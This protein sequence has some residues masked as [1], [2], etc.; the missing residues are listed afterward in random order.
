MT[1]DLMEVAEDSA[2]GSFYLVSGNFIATAVHAITTILVGRLLGPE[3]FGRY[4]LS[5]VIPEL[6]FIFAD[7]GITAGVVK[8]AAS[9]RAEGKVGHATKIIKHA[10]LLRVL[11]GFV[12]SLLNFALADF[13]AAVF[14]N[15]PDLG[16]YVR[17]LSI[18]I[19]FRVIY[20]VAIFA[21]IGLDKAQ[22]SA[23][24]TNIEAISKLIISITLILLGLGLA[25]AV[26]GHVGGLVIGGVVA[27]SILLL[28]LRKFAK[29]GDD[30]FGFSGSCKTLL[31][32]GGPLYV[33]AIL[34]GFVHPYQKFILA[35][36][37]TNVEIGN[38][39]AAQNFTA[40][41]AIFSVSI[42]NA[43]FP[44]FSKLDSAKNKD[45]QTF[46]KF[47]NK[48]TT[49][50]IVPLATLLIVFSEEIVQMVYGSTYQTAPFFLS[51]DCLIF[52]L[53]GVGYITLK[54]LFYGS[55]ET[56]IALKRSIMALL[57]ILVL[58]PV[59]TKAYGVPGVI[60]SLISAQLVSTSYG[61]YYAKR[62]LR[63]ELDT[64]SLIKIYV[65]GAVSAVPSLLLLQ[66]SMFSSVVNVILGGLLYIITFVTLTPI[67]RIQ[68]KS[69]LKR[70]TELLQKIKPLGLVIKPLLK[71]QEKILNR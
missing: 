66:V 64:K 48:Y 62:K 35:F 57:T 42:T 9:L 39:K 52:F 4:A 47:V 65:V 55:G 44:A 19:V 8:F 30:D 71:Y 60:M 24:T 38:F 43:L 36:F 18:S 49:L 6:L 29:S 53:V 51:I 25:G 58:S 11:S 3:L 20:D 61:M 21:H 40:L 46:F 59:L 70:A 7:F 23:L 12:F 67:T 15:R 26:L 54:S 14:L 63:I 69:E 32:Y 56:R 41:L 22:Y 28:I 13:F 16:F 17:L 2:R 45:M 1:S 68:D 10:I 33:S 34:V 31:S 5:L 27:L 50:L 37:A